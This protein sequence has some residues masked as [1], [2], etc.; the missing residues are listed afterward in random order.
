MA[1]LGHRR[2]CTSRSAGKKRR[3]VS[4]VSL[5]HQVESS[6]SL[7]GRASAQTEN[8]LGALSVRR[9]GLPGTGCNTGGKADESFTIFWRKREI[10]I[11]I[12]S[13]GVG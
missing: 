8:T 1:L 13:G 11:E 7:P 6:A 5:H 9:R 12:Y 2:P 3:M 10:E 4:L